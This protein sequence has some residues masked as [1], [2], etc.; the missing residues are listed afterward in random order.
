MADVFWNALD[1][2]MVN[3]YTTAMGA[4]SAYTTMKAKT[5]NKEYYADAF[6]WSTWLLPAIAVACYRVDYALDGHTG[7]DSTLY[8]KTYR[9]AAWGIVG[10][11]LSPTANSTIGTLAE[12]TKEF[13]ER[14]EAPLRTDK[15]AMV[16]AGFRAR[17]VTITSGDCDVIRFTDDGIE[18]TKRLG[19]A[20]I[21]FDIQAS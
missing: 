3:M 10:G 2:Y 17:K 18:S 7:G 12:E 5:V 9:C 16:A 15:F 8:R 13:Y 6:V 1:T 4:G 20:M 14:M 11:V 21:L 19:I